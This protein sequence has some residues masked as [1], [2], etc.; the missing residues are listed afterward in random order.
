MGQDRGFSDTYLQGKLNIH[1]Y[2]SLNN[3]CIPTRLLARSVPSKSAYLE[4][5]AL[6][7]VSGQSACAPWPRHPLFSMECPP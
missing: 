5:Q 6:G 1:T 7:R 3:N 4:A 2:L